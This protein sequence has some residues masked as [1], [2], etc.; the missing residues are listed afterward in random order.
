MKSSILN[1]QFNELL[2]SPTVGIND[3]ST[4]KAVQA[5]IGS[6]IPTV[7]VLPSAW[8]LYDISTLPIY[9]ILYKEADERETPGMTIEVCSLTKY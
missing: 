6:K 8:A 5:P 7:V 9:N 1:H 4:G 3:I 2:E